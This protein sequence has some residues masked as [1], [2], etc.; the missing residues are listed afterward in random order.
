MKQLR[1]LAPVIAL[2]STFAF[3]QTA[4]IV[5]SAYANESVVNGTATVGSG[6]V[7][8][9]N[10]QFPARAKLGTGVVDA[11]GKFAV[12]TKNR[13]LE[14]HGLVVVDRAGR[15]SARFNVAPARSGDAPGKP[16]AK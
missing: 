15:T 10:V 5:A 8:L 1:K 6:P 14:G 4:P 12:A 13:L 3:A 11:T 16:P 7:T 2:F 9:Y